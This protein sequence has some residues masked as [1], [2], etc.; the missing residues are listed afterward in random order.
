MKL[1]LLSPTKLGWKVGRVGGFQAERPQTL[2]LLPRTTVVFQELMLLSA[3]WLTSR[4]L[5]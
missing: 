4:F 1:L 3:F 5:K 2:L